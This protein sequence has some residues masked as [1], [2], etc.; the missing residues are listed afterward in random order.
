MFERRRRLHA[1]THSDTTAP[2]SHDPVNDTLRGGAAMTSS[3]AATANDVLSGDES[4][5]LGGIDSRPRHDEI[6]QGG[7]EVYASA[8]HS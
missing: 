6:D 1:T 2:L 8:A 5:W 7:Y 3:D 4:A